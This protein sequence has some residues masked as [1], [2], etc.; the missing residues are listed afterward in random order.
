[1]G[2][3]DRWLKHYRVLRVLS[4]TAAIVAACM[5][6]AS[7]T[8]AARLSL[9][10]SDVMLLGAPAPVSSRVVVVDIDEKALREH[11]PWPWPREKLAALIGQ[12]AKSNPDVIALDMLLSRRREDC[13]AEPPMGSS[14]DG[15][16]STV[17]SV[18]RSSSNRM[19]ASFDRPT[20]VRILSTNP[21]AGHNSETGD[22]IDTAQWRTADD[23]CRDGQDALRQ[24]LAAAPSVAAALLDVDNDGDDAPAAPI[25][26]A[27]PQP[28]LKPWSGA[29]VLMPPDSVLE[30]TAGVGVA[31]LDAGADGIVRGAPLLA[32]A[33]DAVLPG[34]VVE[35]L[36]LSQGASSIIL[37]SRPDRMTIGT[38]AIPLTIDAQLRFYP[39]TS[40]EQAKR[41]ISAA[42][43][44]S[45]AIPPGDLADKIVLIGGSAAELGAL[46]ETAGGPLVPSVQIHADAI[47]TVLAGAIPYRPHFAPLV[48]WLGLLGMCAVAALLGLSTTPLAALSA[49][50]VLAAGWLGAVIFAFVHGKLL[51]DPAVPGA[52][53]MAA[54]L[55]AVIVGAISSR[56]AA[57]QL[58]QRFEQRLSPEVVQRIVDNL[59]ALRLRGERREITAVFTDIQGFTAMTERVAP[60]TLVAILDQYFSGVTAIVIAHGGMVDKIVG[61]AVHALFNA[62]FDLADYQARAI[63]C[64][65]EIVAFSEAFRARP[66]ISRHGLGRTRIGIETGPV[67]LG[68]VGQGAK[69]DYTA[70]GSA[71]NTAARLEALNKQFGTSICVG[72]VT[73]QRASRHAFRSLGT[74]DV[75]GRGLLEVFEPIP[76]VVSPDGAD[77]LTVDP[78]AS[79]ISN[80]SRAA[81]GSRRP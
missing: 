24:A 41:T 51:I 21:P 28:R 68:D 56:R 30:A 48:E 52:A 60:E 75:R 55:C 72:P 2:D 59:G 37:S 23:I 6:A 53:T 45:G 76:P 39:S 81:S 19:G 57:R 71:V 9:W 77:L 25:V 20:P 32:L 17:P 14:M 5:A 63:D 27:P 1:M 38:A 80:P 8:G 79:A 74:V 11:G 46:R 3:H 36:R 16:A 22:I 66:D 12:V 40:A 65:F 70:H 42:D 31:S 33:G 7:T 64:A 67:V 47:E 62:P 78:I 61:D 15:P 26:V 69:L 10:A 29:G 58:R 34:F 35:T 49:A 44:L 50:F 54:S 43:L 13:A 18:Y 4:L 73:R